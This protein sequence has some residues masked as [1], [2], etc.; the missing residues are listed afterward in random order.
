[1]LHADVHGKRR[2]AGPRTRAKLVVPSPSVLRLRSSETTCADRQLVSE[3]PTALSSSVPV[4]CSFLERDVSSCTTPVRDRGPP[5][6]PSAI[7]ECCSSLNFRLRS[8]SS[9]CVRAVDVQT[10]VLQRE[11][12]PVPHRDN[13]AVHVF[14]AERLPCCFAA[15]CH[16]RDSFPPWRRRGLSNRIPAFAQNSTSRMSSDGAAV[17]RRV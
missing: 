12:S 11:I 8:S 15:R 4:P 10:A 17:C 1:M 16:H 13:T 2:G 3:R 7:R 9:A 5:C 6:R 14:A